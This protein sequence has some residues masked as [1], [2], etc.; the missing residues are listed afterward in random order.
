MKKLKFVRLVCQPAL[1]IPPIKRG[2][3]GCPSG[4]QR[5][6]HHRT[7]SWTPF[8]RGNNFHFLAA[9]VGSVSGSVASFSEEPHTAKGRVSEAPDPLTR[10]GA[11]L[12]PQGRC[13]KIGRA[14]LPPSRRLASPGSMRLGGSLA[15]PTRP[16]LNFF[17]PSGGA[18]G[19]PVANMAVESRSTPP[20][21]PFDRGIFR[22]AAHAA[23]RGGTTKHENE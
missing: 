4:F 23:L 14:R 3:G 2:A 6:V 5:H 7:S 21:A 1:K 9:T 22:G 17:T 8:G 19:C 12:T 16:V 10:S 20:Y 15:L 13:E 18:G 11:T